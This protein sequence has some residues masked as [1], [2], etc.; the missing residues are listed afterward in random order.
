MDTCGFGTRVWF[1]LAVTRRA[2]SV[3]SPFDFCFF[4]CFFAFLRSSVE[5]ALFY[6][7]HRQWVFFWLRFLVSVRLRAK[8]MPT[9]IVEESAF[10]I[11][12]F[13]KLLYMIFFERRFWMLQRAIN[14]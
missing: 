9:E 4:F 8:N 13:G 6:E 12:T 1:D 7:E 5:V 2:V 14:M 10:D 3:L 11:P